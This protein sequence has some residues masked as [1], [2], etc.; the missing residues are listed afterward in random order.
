[1]EHYMCETVCKIYIHT[2]SCRY[3]RVILKWRLSLAK[4]GV[5]SKNYRLVNEK[6]Y[7]CSV[8]GKRSRDPFYLMHTMMSSSH[9][10]FKSLL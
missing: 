3:L 1:M 4:N 6:V 10:S 5:V 8:P 2:Q 7:S 9:T